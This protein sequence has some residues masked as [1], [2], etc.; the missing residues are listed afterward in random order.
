MR[1]SS[2]I[3]L[4]VLLSLQCVLSL[5]MDPSPEARGVL[6]IRT[7]TTKKATTVHAK[8]AKPVKAAPAKKTKTKTV[9]PA[10][11]KPAKVKPVKAAVPAKAKKTKTKAKT[12]PKAKAPAPV[13]AAKPKATVKA[14]TPK[15]TPPKAADKAPVAPAKGTT[16]STTKT[17]S[18]TSS[19]AVPAGASCPVPAKKTK[20]RRMLEFLGLVKR[21]PPADCDT[22][23]S[24]PAVASKKGLRKQKQAAAKAAKAAADAPAPAEGENAE[25]GTSATTESGTEAEPEPAEPA[26]EEPPK[27]AKS[28]KGKGKAAAAEEPAA[29]PAAAPAAP[30]APAKAPVGTVANKPTKSVKCTNSKGGQTTVATQNLL[31]AITRAQETAVFDQTKASTKG[32]FPHVFNNKIR[33]ATTGRLVAEVNFPAGPCQTEQL[34]EQAV[35]ANMQKFSNSIR[36]DF[37]FRV[38]ITKPDSKGDTTFCGVITHGTS[39]APVAQGEKPPPATFLPDPCPNA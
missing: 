15:T 38:V 22:G 28:S 18:A 30:A 13:K 9:K 35:G 26:A 1:F 19:N 10:K 20:G 17:T 23:S 34:I 4:A 5:P 36:E 11:V 32:F 33:S 27:A 37:P 31:L 2:S 7:K 16:S 6:D 39:T 25:A 3:F 14:K 24:T 8:P 29:A 12:V 21:T